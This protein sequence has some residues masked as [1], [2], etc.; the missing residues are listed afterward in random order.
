MGADTDIIY[1]FI[2]LF[3]YLLIYYILTLSF[4]QNIT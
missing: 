3:T 4:M 2:Y 1:L